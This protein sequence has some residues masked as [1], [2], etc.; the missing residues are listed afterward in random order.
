MVHQGIQLF[1]GGLFEMAEHSTL[2]LI[3]TNTTTLLATFIA[4]KT[5]MKRRHDQL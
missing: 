2:L 5:W 3:F 4:T 1:I